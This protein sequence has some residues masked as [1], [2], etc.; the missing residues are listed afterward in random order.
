[1]TLTEQFKILDDKIKANKAQYELDGEAVKISA[2]SS[3]E[4]E[5]YE[6]L[7]G[8]DL[9]YKPDV[10]QKSKFEYSPT[11]Q[12]FKKG[13]NTDD[14]KEG[15]LKRLKNIEDKTD[16]PLEENKDLGVTSIEELSQEA[17]NILE[18]LNSQ[19][20]LINYKKLNFRGGNN[21]DYDFSKYRSLK[22]LFRAICYR[23]VT[24]EEAERVQEEFDAIIGALNVYDAR[25]LK[26][27]EGK[28]KLLI[29]AKKFYD[30]REMIVNAF[31]N[32]ILPLV[33][34]DYTSDDDRRLRPDS[35][36]S[37]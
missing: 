2:L 4:L 12:V 5:K 34:S 31:K 8:E 1:M 14:K 26:Y 10:I 9:R 15:L 17:K 33:P 13:L 27:K 18:L 16:K 22:K 29:N 7:T 25:K 24:I 28:T 23:K 36:T 6:Y 19:E 30:G 35:P 3:S 21:I 37:S 32:G 11:S 20:K